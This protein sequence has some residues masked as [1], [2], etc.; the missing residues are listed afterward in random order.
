ML[1]HSVLLVI[2]GALLTGLL[3]ALV[4]G[5]N[6]TAEERRIR[7]QQ[8]LL[9]ALEAQRRIRDV[10]LM[11]QAR[12]QRQPHRETPPPLRIEPVAVADGQAVDVEPK[13]DRRAAEHR[14]KREEKEQAAALKSERNAEKRAQRHAEQEHK[15]AVKAEQ[16]TLRVAER[17]QKQSAKSAA[18]AEQA[19]LR[20]AERQ[21]REEAKA[22]QA[23]ARAATARVKPPPTP[24][25][26]KRTTMDDPEQVKPLAELPLFSWAHRIEDDDKPSRDVS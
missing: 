1:S 2:G 3:G 17:Q 9:R 12:Q 26:A 7:E 5:S 4:F 13:P 20:A 15:S 19:T 6:G 22:Q 10:Q 24:K 14:R 11:R 21:Q 18:K 16:E 8:K 25:P 23:A